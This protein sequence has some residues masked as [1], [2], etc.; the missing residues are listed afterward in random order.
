MSYQ[1]VYCLAMFSE[2]RKYACAVI[3]NC[4]RELT[5]YLIKPGLI[6]PLSYNVQGP[7]YVFL[8]RI[9]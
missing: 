1:R 6:C 9:Q 7:I 3:A 4:Q 5:G 8:A 2:L